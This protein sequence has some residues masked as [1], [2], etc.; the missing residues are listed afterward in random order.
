V[1]KKNYFAPLPKLDEDKKEVIWSYFEVKES[2]N[3]GLGLFCKLTPPH[4][5]VGMMLP[6]GGVPVRG[7]HDISNVMKKGRAN[8]VVS[9][10][11]DI[12]LDG[13]FRH[14]TPRLDLPKFAWIATYCNEA[15]ADSEENY[16]ARFLH[17]PSGHQ[18]PAYPYVSRDN[19]IIVVLEIVTKVRKGMEILAPYHWNKN[20]YALLGYR[21]KSFMPEDIPGWR[22]PWDEP[23]LDTPTDN[24]ISVGNPNYKRRY[25]NDEWHEVLSDVAIKKRRCARGKFVKAK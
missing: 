16:N 9:C 20:R 10:G 5:G 11:K 3:K 7:S 2:P 19:D 23:D 18:M 24:T 13:D 12:A 4:G 17:W 6:Y 1:L 21:P 15:S 25:D 8:Y 14:W 22:K